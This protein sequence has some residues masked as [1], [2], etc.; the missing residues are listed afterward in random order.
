MAGDL[1]PSSS[2]TGVKV[3]A[4]ARSTRRPVCVEPVNS[5]LSKGSPDIS[6]A[7]SGPPSIAMTRSGSRWRA[8]AAH[9][10]AAVRGVCSD[11]FNTTRQPAASAPIT[12]ERA[13]WTG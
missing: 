13:S 11:G 12:G 5:S 3:S 9:R 6:A 4:A 8:T 2:T 10:A 7:T 1:P